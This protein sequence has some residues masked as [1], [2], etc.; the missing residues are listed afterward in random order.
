MTSPPAMTTARMPSG[1][2]RQR[3]ARPARQLVPR[4]SVL[5]RLTH[6]INV[7]CFSLL[8]MSGAQIFN[9]HP[10]LY[11][12]E[13]GAD[14]DHAWLSMDSLRSNGHWRGVLHVGSLTV[15]TTG[16][17]GASRDAAGNL[18][19]RGFPSWLTIPSYQDL[20]DGRHWHFF[21]AWLFAINGA[22]Y[23]VGGLLSR[24]FRRDLL[25]T[26]AE[27]APSH[28][29]REVVD[30]AKLDFP[31]GE[32]AR[33]YNVLQKL[34]YLAVAFVLLPGMVLTGLTMSP[35]LDSAFP[36]LLDL[37]GG[38]PSAR[39]LHFIFASALV[40]FVVVHLVMVLVSGVWN[41]LRS[42]ITGRYAIETKEDAR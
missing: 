41:N 34:S 38:R 10:R 5:V 13:Y 12:G 32:A 9:A 6:W 3:A 16:V 17:L 37:F 40:A 4:H 28:L 27:L 25:P 19:P 21:F 29:A 7:L 26:R 39:S 11:W 15:E 23:L 24:H 42:M 31:K 14:H 18:Q 1:M 33:H 30:H 8:L 20:A 35:G 22:V 36:F 2:F